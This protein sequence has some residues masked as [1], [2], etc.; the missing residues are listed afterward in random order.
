MLVYEIKLQGTTEQYGRLD[1]A[2]RT[3]RFIRNSII[4]AWMDGWRG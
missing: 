2:I 3:G 4:K 1:Q